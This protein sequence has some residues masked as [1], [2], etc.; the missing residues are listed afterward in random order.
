MEASTSGTQQIL[1]SLFF[2]FLLALLQVIEATQ[3]ACTESMCTD[4]QGLAIHV[5]FRLRYHDQTVVD[6][7]QKVLV[8]YF[9]KH[10][11]YIHQSIQLHESDRCLLLKP[12]EMPIFSFYPSYLNSG[13]E[14]NFTLFRCPT[15]VDKRD[16]SAIQVPCISQPAYRIYASDSDGG[17]FYPLQTL[18]SCTKLYDV[19]TLPI[20][21]FSWESNDFHLKWSTPNCTECEA[22]GKRC[23]FNSNG[24]KSAIECAYFWKPNKNNTYLCFM[25][26]DVMFMRI[27]LLFLIHLYTRAKSLINP[28]NGNFN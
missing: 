14:F 21:P 22:Q 20:F 4:N 26:I 9:V 10:I 19:L 5:P 25:Y 7:H 11:D 27:F 24:T 13:S 2:L 16:T 3:N 17:L 18:Q 15:D 1:I 6:K 23:R 8:K 12:F 28:S